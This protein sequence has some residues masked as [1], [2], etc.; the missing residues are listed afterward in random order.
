MRNIG[1]TRELFERLL[2]S[3][4]VSVPAVRPAIRKIRGS[5]PAKLPYCRPTENNVFAIQAARQIGM[6][7][8][9]SEG[10]DEPRADYERLRG[11]A[12][13]ALSREIGVLDAARALAPLLSKFPDMA[14]EEDSK[15]IVGVES[16]TDHLPLGHVREQW[17]AGALAEKDRGI[18]RCEDLW[19]DQFRATCERILRRSQ[20]AL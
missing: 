15:F 14:L 18:A 5:E 19:G 7:R 1:K 11:I 8:R 16:E 17:E 20:S 10:M 2:E 6:L 4:D 12:K 9:V 3:E 13:A